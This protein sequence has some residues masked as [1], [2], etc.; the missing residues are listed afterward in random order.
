MSSW[1]YKTTNL[2]LVCSLFFVFTFISVHAQSIV[3]N[4]VMSSNANTLFD[5]DNDTPDWIEL[6]NSSPNTINL[7]GY[8]ISDNENEPGKWIFPELSF[9]SGE[10][11]TIFA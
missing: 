9:E 2:I 5:E 3:I 11:L 8:S 6:F 4:E 10:F 7:S 1:K